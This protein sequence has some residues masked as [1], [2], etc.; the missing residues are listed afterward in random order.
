MIRTFLVALMAAAC[1]GSILAQGAAVPAQ[2]LQKHVR[3]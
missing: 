2:M 1:A 3:R